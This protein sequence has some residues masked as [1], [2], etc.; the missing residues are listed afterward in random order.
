MTKILRYA[1][2]FVAAATPIVTALLIE[3]A[4]HLSTTSTGIVAAIATAILVFLVPNRQPQ[5]EA[6]EP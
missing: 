1:K 5:P 3:V 2:A 4:G 6:G